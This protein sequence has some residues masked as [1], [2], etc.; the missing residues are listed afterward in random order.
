MRWG[1]RRRKRSRRRRSGN[2]RAIAAACYA[3]GPMLRFAVMDSHTLII[4]FQV[5]G[6]YLLCEYIIYNSRH[7][8]VRVFTNVDGW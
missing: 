7:N 4:T 5:R 3:P 1:R 8:C 2:E 6:Q